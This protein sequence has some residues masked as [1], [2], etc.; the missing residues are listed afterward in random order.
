MSLFGKRHTG[1]SVVLIDVGARSVTGG[2]AHF[3]ADVLPQLVYTTRVQIEFRDGELEQEAV[4]RALTELDEVLIRDG[5]PALLRLTGRGSADAILVSVDAPWQRTFVRSEYLEEQKPFVFSRRLVASVLEKTQAKP[6]GKILVDESVIGTI[7]NGYETKDPYDKEVHRAEIVILTSLIDESIANAIITTLE[8][9]YHTKNVYPIAGS[10][11]RYQVIRTVFPH[12]RD[13]LI[14][15]VTEP[16][17]SIALV[18]RDL[19]MAHSQV[20]ENIATV[21]GWVQQIR[22]ELAELARQFPLPRTIFLLAREP[23]IFGLQEALAAAKLGDLWLSDSPPTV[24]PV[25]AG[26]LAN[27]VQQSTTSPAD[28]L[29]LLMTLYWKNQSTP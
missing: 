5:A 2:Y 29:M 17:T 12:E 13:A 3:P 18:R 7:L 25:V 20:T 23:E 28:L 1:E 6:T 27:F 22:T 8:H 24:V 21:E 26:Q 10:S 14:F 19:F 9:A 11:L 15:D 4:V 16:L